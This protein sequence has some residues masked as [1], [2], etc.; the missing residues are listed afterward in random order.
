MPRGTCILCG[1]TDAAACPEGCRWV[2]HGHEICSAHSIAEVQ[3]AY[4][5]L[6]AKPKAPPP[7]A[8]VSPLYWRQIRSGI[9]VADVP[10]G[11]YKIARYGTIWAIQWKPRKGR[12][13]AITYG[14]PESKAKEACEKHRLERIAD[15]M[16]ENSGASELVKAGLKGPATA[17]RKGR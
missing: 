15:T 17:F 7:R 6:T 4:R 14:L 13:K 11:Q 10:A 3:A 12:G 5:K 16:L 9:Q 2:D 1:C 8:A